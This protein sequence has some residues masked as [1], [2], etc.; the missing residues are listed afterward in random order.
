M[1]VHKVKG[2]YKHTN[3][4]MHIYIY[5]FFLK[6]YTWYYL[7]VL[8]V[9]HRRWLKQVE[10]GLGRRR[11]SIMNENANENHAVQKTKPEEKRERRRTVFYYRF[12]ALF[13]GSTKF[14]IDLTCFKH[15]FLEKRRC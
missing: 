8:D 6:Y 12:L 4:H 14:F 1:Q 2:K 13:D 11:Q 3:L 5:F 7:P 15:N 9:V 10:Q